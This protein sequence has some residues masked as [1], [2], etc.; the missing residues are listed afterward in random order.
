M[1]D[2][3][4]VIDSFKKEY[5]F[6]AAMNMHTLFGFWNKVVGKKFENNSKCEQINNKGILTVA[7]RNSTVS[8]ELLMFKEEILKKINVY[9]KPLDI[10]VADIV[11]SHK[12][13][14][15]YVCAIHCAK[16]YGSVKHEFHVAGTGGFFGS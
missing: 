10:T 4:E 13:V 6:D 8:N 15:F 9:A 16:S 12:V 3:A 2:I 14:D 5:N 1:S 7:C 11:F